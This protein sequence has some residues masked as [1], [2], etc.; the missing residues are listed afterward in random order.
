MNLVDLATDV[1]QQAVVEEE[2]DENEEEEEESTIDV[3]NALKST[4]FKKYLN[5]VAEIAKVQITNK[6][7]V[8]AKLAFYLNVY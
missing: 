4:E 8:H 5:A 6:M 7:G 3:E 1:Y 2:D